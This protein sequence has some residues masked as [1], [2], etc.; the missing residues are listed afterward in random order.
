MVP[1]DIIT[2]S[3]KASYFSLLNIVLADFYIALIV[4]LRP[5]MQ[6]HK[7]LDYLDANASAKSQKCGAIARLIN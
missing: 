1:W 3:I 7:S 2:V 4:K 6:K 5:K